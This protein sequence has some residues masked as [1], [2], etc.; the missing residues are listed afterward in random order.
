MIT[1]EAIIIVLCYSMIG[2]K[3]AML[4]FAKGETLSIATLQVSVY[5][6]FFS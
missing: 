2:E 5:I 4:A 6:Q 1:Q 3:L